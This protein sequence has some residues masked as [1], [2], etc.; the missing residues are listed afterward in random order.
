MCEINLKV[1]EDCV[2]TF[3]Y[4][5]HCFETGCLEMSFSLLHYDL[6]RL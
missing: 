6:D 5:V 2:G 1:G 3:I 4:H